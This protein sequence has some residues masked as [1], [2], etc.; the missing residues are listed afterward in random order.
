MA[1]RYIEAIGRRKTSTARVRVYKGKG[2]STVNDKPV[3][4]FFPHPADVKDL[5]SPITLSGLDNEV[6]FT[7]KVSGGGTTGSKGAIQL[8]LARALVKMDET[9]KPVLRKAG[10][11]TRDSRMVERKKYG[12]KKARK[13]PQFSKR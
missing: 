3:D 4:V 6:Y 10:L 2:T 5:L 11:M 7:V 12:L 13:K 8:G 9:F 1:E